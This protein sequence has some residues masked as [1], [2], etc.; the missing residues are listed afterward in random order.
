VAADGGLAVP[1]WP[2]CVGDQP[3]RPGAGEEGSQPYLGARGAGCCPGDK[4]FDRVS[5]PAGMR[6][7][8]LIGPSAWLLAAGA[9]SS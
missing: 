4:M 5:P 2:F 3:W 7:L 9:G 1:R 6:P 8:S